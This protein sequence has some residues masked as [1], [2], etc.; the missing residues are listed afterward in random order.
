MMKDY[1]QFYK[2]IEC[3][4]DNIT[5]ITFEQAIN[6]INRVIEVLNEKSELGIPKVDHKKQFEEIIFERIERM[7]AKK[8]GGGQSVD[9]TS[10]SRPSANR[11][12][13]RSDKKDELLTQ[14]SERLISEAKAI[15]EAYKENAI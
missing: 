2:E 6:N 13:L 5:V 7:N 3:V 12:K 14:C 10:V 15:Y 4:I 8:F 9:E 1:V 11:S